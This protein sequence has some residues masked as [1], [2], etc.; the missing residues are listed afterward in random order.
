MISPA[1]GPPS[2]ADDQPSFLAII[3][4]ELRN[5]LSCILAQAETLQDGLHGPVSPAQQAVLQLIQDDVRRT[6]ALVSDL[7]DLGRIEAGTLTFNPGPCSLAQIQ[8]EVLEQVAPM[9]QARSVHLSCAPL[10]EGAQVFAD[11]GRLRQVIGELLSAVLLSSPIGCPASLALT[12]SGATGLTVQAGSGLTADELLYIPA[13]AGEDAGSAAVL[14]RLLSLKPL[15]FTLLRKLVQILGG[16]FTART[17]PAGAFCL[18]IHLP[19]VAG[20]ASAPP[21]VTEAS[22]ETPPPTPAALDRPPV[23][24]LADDQPTLLTVTTHYLENLGFE[25]HTARDG[26]EAIRQ[27]Q[28]LRPDLILMDVRMPV[29]DGPQAIRTLRSSEDP[30]IRAIPIISVSGQ[31]GAADK[32]RCLAAGA[33]AHLAKPF[34]IKELDQAIRQFVTPPQ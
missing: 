28:D 3:G 16:T 12:P 23:I 26:Q 11:A 13:D 1:S 14:Q 5:P 15:G 8:R 22:V 20:P 29:L 25:V 30:A 6:L 21:R 33:T 32:D 4:H 9:A 7:A 18:G 2:D 17:S 27:A 19:L 24:L 31:S 10:A 34:G